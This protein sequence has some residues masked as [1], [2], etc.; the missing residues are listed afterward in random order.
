M[1]SLEISRRRQKGMPLQSIRKSK[2]KRKRLN[3]ISK[4]K[5][6]RDWQKPKSIQRSKEINFLKGIPRKE[7][8]FLIRKLKIQLALTQI[9][10]YKSKKS[11]NSYL[12]SMTLRLSSRK[13]LKEK[14]EIS[15]LL[16]KTNL[17]FLM[18]HS[19]IK[20]DHLI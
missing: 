12:K 11:S 14:R 10:M 3:W 17:L 7:L 18:F 9:S 2:R 8:L 15:Q 4:P 1:Q 6:K 13:N 19:K 5:K 16:Y 20:E